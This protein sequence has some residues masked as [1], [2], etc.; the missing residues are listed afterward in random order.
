MT[1]RD[2][3]KQKWQSAFFMPEHMSILKNL[4]KDYY[5]GIKPILDE[6]QIE[7]LES[8]I[9]YAIEFTYPV[10]LTTW[11]DG[12]EWGYKG[13]VYRLEPLTKMIHL[14]LENEESY[15]MK[16]RFKDIVRVEVEERTGSK[17]E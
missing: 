1:L 11:E 2:R 9:C 6:Y 17:H 5:R 15:I 14:E 7:E 10:K 8:K 4:S 3:G 16:I 12:F 13:L